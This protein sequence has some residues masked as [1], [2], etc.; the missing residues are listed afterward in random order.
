MLQCESASSCRKAPPGVCRTAWVF[1]CDL[2]SPFK[3]DLESCMK[4]KT[5]GH[6]GLRK[7]VKRAVFPDWTMSEGLEPCWGAQWANSGHSNMAPLQMGS[8]FYSNVLSFNSPLSFLDIG[9]RALLWNPG[10]SQTHGSLLSQTPQCWECR[11]E[12]PCLSVL[13]HY[14]PHVIRHMWLATKA[15]ESSTLLKAIWLHWIALAEGL[16]WSAHFHYI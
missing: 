14:M 9:E 11:P 8:N 4:N 6:W 10:W 5:R 3:Q 2:R 7:K 15:T 1:N 12:L 13:E 16:Y